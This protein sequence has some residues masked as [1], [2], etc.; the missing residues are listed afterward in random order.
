MGLHDEI[1]MPELTMP[2]DKFEKALDSLNDRINETGQTFSNM[3]EKIEK[4]ATDKI[5]HSVDSI[6]KSIDKMASGNNMAKYWKSQDALIED[7]TKTYGKLDSAVDVL[8]KRNLSQELYKTFN[9]LKAVSDTNFGNLQDLE[10]IKKASE[11]ISKAN[12]RDAF[13]TEFNSTAFREMFSVFE[14]MENSGANVR[15]VFDAISKGT[16]FDSVSRELRDVKNQLEN[17]A[18]ADLT[19]IQN[20]L[21]NLSRS[22][23]NEFKTFLDFHGISD[24]APQVEEYFERLENGAMTSQDAIKEFKYW[25][26][27]LL[28]GNKNAA[29]SEIFNTA[30]MRQMTEMIAEISFKVS[31]LY[32]N[33]NINSERQIVDPVGLK[34]LN[35]TFDT[36]SNHLQ[37]IRRSLGSVDDDLEINTILSSVTKLN[38]SL[39]EVVG[40]LERISKSNFSS[41][42]SMSFGG[43]NENEKEVESYLETTLQQL[44]ERYNRFYKKSADY[45]LDSPLAGIYGSLN[46]LP[47]KYSLTEFENMFSPQAI[48]NITDITDRIRRLI[49]FMNI[50]RQAV[51]ENRGVDDYWKSLAKSQIVS[52]NQLYNIDTVTKNI[53]KIR[54][55]V[56]E[57]SPLDDMFKTDITPLIEQIK[58]VIAKFDEMMAIF[59]SNEN[60]NGIV[61][62]ANQSIQA[63]NRL[64]EAF[65]RFSKE[66]KEVLDGLNVNVLGGEFTNK[67]PVLKDTTTSLIEEQ[68]KFQSEVSQSIDKVDELGNAID[69]LK[70]HQLDVILKEN[71]AEDD[72]H[73]WIRE[74][75]DIKTFKETLSDSDWAGWEK[76][77]FDPDYTAKMVHE[78]LQSGKITVYSSYDIQNGTFVSPSKMEA[79]S[80]SSDGKVYSKEVALDEVAWIDPTQ[81]Q[82]VAK[83]FDDIQE[84]ASKAT[85]AIDE[86]TNAQEK[87]VNQSKEVANVNSK[88]RT[89]L[90][91]KPVADSVNDS[92]AKLQEESKAM[93][94]VADSARDAANA[95]KD[96][97]TANEGVQSSIDGSKSPLKLEAELMNQIVK[98]AREA[99]DAKEEFAKA[100]EK[101]KNSA[102]TSTPAI[103]E[104]SDVL[105]NILPSDKNF[106]S[107]LKNLDLTKSKL[108]EI[109]KITRQAHADDDGKFYES[110]VLKD[111]NGS[112]ETYGQSSNTSKGQL[113]RYNY[114]EKDVKAEERALKEIAKA[115]EQAAKAEAKRIQELHKRLQLQSQVNQEEKASERKDSANAL[116][117]KQQ[118]KFEQIYQIKTQIAKLDKN[119]D[120]Y[121]SSLSNLEEAKKKY[122]EEF[123]AINR[124]LGAYDDII[125]RQKQSNALDDIAK[126]A[127]REIANIEKEIAKA[128]GTANA[129]KLQNKAY[130]KLQNFNIKYG[131]YSQYYDDDFDIQ[132]KVA[133]IRESILSITSDTDLSKV[134]AQIKELGNTLDKVQIPKDLTK[135]KW[136][137]KFYKWLNENTKAVKAYG[138]EIEQLKKDYANIDT[139]GKQE[140]FGVDFTALMKKAE[141]D[142]N[143]GLTTMDTIIKRAKSMSASFVGMYLSL[144]DIARYAK[145][146]IDTIRELDY[147]LVDLKKT[148]TMTSSELNQFYYDANESAKKYGVTTKEIIEQASSWARLGYSSKE[149][150]TKMAELSSKFAAISP[151]MDTE[152]AQSG[153][154]SIMKA[155]KHAFVYRNMHIEYI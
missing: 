140:K 21:E 78:A 16:Q 81:G 46:E 90:S 146:S 132:N 9:A 2:T 138:A 53:D 3:A 15:K 91:D 128:D 48:N 61:D 59:R 23:S 111:R 8:E 137:N 56:A 79:E 7:L 33:I 57:G 32:S 106:D 120:T 110:Y 51:S 50:L 20:K 89:L 94:T 60:G 76:T 67:T 1:K 145:N 75:E 65:E 87:L 13:K 101:V 98:S 123:I 69:R 100:N 26:D 95:K 148:T 82:F 88:E 149:E 103:K 97:T 41:N 40:T 108:G 113:L 6:V 36:L 121:Q 68:N 49:E 18:S 19:E 124:Q 39:T 155:N 127:K 73:T 66:S 154:V 54:N 52:S 29:D 10:I 85:T 42:F 25:Y 31:E 37:E 70:K 147:A 96:F 116:L 34:Q 125:D 43:N 118:E 24:Q 141:K 5:K 62:F 14:Q 112:T 38:S 93:E 12:Y 102:D 144:Y 47:V 64:T 129:Q 28:E 153:M 117:V 55:T 142:G 143:V 17:I 11:W 83:V 119:S 130:S 114:I 99:A 86:V 4:D 126:K 45:G 133:E 27:Y 150:A 35:D 115:D 71:P 63:I 80:Y 135:E 151:E 136:G 139:I 84:N 77:G 72:L 22:A 58:E 74:L 44:Q 131:A 109:V 122:Q 134:N 107:T 104:E 92:K 105:E 30:E 152:Q